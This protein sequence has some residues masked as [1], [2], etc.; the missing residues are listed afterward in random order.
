MGVADF[1]LS[2][3]A[4]CIAISAVSAFALL[5]SIDNN[6]I[7]KSAKTKVLISLVSSLIVGLGCIFAMTLIS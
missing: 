2:V 4:L 3:G 1:L 5:I 7:P 6:D